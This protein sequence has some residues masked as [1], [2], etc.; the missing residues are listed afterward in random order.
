[1]SSFLLSLLAKQLGR[2]ICSISLSLSTSSC[3]PLRGLMDSTTSIS[4]TSTLPALW[5]IPFRWCPDNPKTLRSRTSSKSSRL[6]V[7]LAACLFTAAGLGLRNHLLGVCLLDLG[8]FGFLVSRFLYLVHINI[9]F[10]LL[11]SAPEFPPPSYNS[12]WILDPSTWYF[13][14]NRLQPIR[15]LGQPV[16]L[17]RL[18]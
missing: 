1:M 9:R 18:R 10:I 8:Q 2:F 6:T 14:P 3:P 13:L 12:S 5:L 7:L 11:T 17:S 16:D 15:F 4:R